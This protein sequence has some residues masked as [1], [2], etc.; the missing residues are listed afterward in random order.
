[1]HLHKEIFGAIVQINV[2]SIT[3][4]LAAVV[5]SKL[6]ELK[7][8]TLLALAEEML[9]LEAFKDIKQHIVS[10]TVSP[11]WEVDLNSINYARHTTYPHVY[12]NNLLRREKSIVKDLITNGYGA[13]SSGTSLSSICWEWAAS[14]LN[15][16]RKEL[17][18]N[19]VQ[20]IYTISDIR[21][22]KKLKTTHIF[23]V[24]YKHFT[25]CREI[26]K[27]VVDGLLDEKKQTFPAFS[28]RQASGG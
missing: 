23:T 12:L 17:L 8:P 27:E 7:E 18:T 3:K 13:W 6:T 1:M 19:S 2:E 20:A 14:Y 26:H 11:V 10:L 9:K 22:V 21:A 15:K 5:S 24:R 4:N 28:P 25:T 16:K